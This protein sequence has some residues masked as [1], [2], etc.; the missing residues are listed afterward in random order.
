MAKSMRDMALVSTAPVKAP[1]WVVSSSRLM[2]LPLERPSSQGRST[3]RTRN[4][5]QASVAIRA[6]GYG[7]TSGASDF[8]CPRLSKVRT[9]WRPVRPGRTPAHMVVSDNRPFSST[10][11]GP[12][13]FPWT[14]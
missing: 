9:R 3:P 13:G 4:N 14:R 7:P 6:V 10:S 1:G 5:S 12:W 8:P 11:Q 2:A